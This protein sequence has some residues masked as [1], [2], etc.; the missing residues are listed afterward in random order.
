[1]DGDDVHI[2]LCQNQTRALGGFGKVEGKQG[3][4]LFKDR[5][6]AGV[7][8]LGSLVVQRSAA[9]GDHIAP[10]VDDRKDDAVG[11]TVVRSV[12]SFGHHIG[13]Q[14]IVVRKTLG[15]QMVEQSVPA[16]R[17]IAQ[18]KVADGLAVPAAADEI[19]IR[20]SA[21][22]GHQAGVEKP[23]RLAVDLQY[24]LFQHRT[25]VRLVAVHR[26][27]Q[28]A[29][30]RQQLDRLHILQ[31]FDAADEGNHI[32]SRSASEAV[33]RL[34]LRIDI[35]RRALFRVEGTQSHQVAPFFL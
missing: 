28:P 11:K 8:V 9:K 35:K 31:I 30:V 2:P 12:F 5:R 4:A 22:L 23:C 34:I 21:L 20:L 33:E 6:I 27:L 16:C 10:Q 18:S 26:Q 19:L 25:R 29:A 3:L 15:A 1:M 7:E 32:A 13:F 24:P 17:R 14:H